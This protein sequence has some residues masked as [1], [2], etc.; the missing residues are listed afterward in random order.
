MPIEYFPTLNA[1]LNGT[2]A[3]LLTLGYFFIRRRQINAHRFVML[4]ALT[5]SALFLIC[6]LIY[7][8]NAGTTRFQGPSWAKTLYLF[9]LIPHTILAAI[10]VPFILVTVSRAL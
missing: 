9:I 6:Y 8:Y 2:S 10:M 1:I 4:T 3:V 5:T 7:H